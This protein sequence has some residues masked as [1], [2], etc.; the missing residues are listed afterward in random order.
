MAV[1][2]DSV[3]PCLLVC[4][5]TRNRNKKMALSSGN[6][7]ESARCCALILMLII[8]VIVVLK[9]ICEAHVMLG[10]CMLGW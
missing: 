1:L 2:A 6:G 5:Y 8:S 9:S 3:C 4:T 7:L 10:W